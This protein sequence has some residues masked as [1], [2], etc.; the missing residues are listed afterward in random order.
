MWNH[1]EF[2][3]HVKWVL[4]GALVYNIGKMVMADPD[5]QENSKPFID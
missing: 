1:V 4:K 2:Q 5:L 3:K